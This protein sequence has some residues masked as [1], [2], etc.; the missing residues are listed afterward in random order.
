MSE[1]NR[2]CTDGSFC[3]LPAAIFFASMEGTEAFVVMHTHSNHTKHT[4]KH[5]IFQE[6]L[7]EWPT[8]KVV[9]AW[10][11]SEEARTRR[12]SAAPPNSAHRSASSAAR[13]QSD[14]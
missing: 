8:R 7:K 10:V 1:A 14:Q 3:S 9:E 5:R 6:E 13:F 11:T 4:P 12:G 2:R